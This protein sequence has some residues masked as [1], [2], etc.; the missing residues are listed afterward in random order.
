MSSTHM[1]SPPAATAPSIVLN[2][3][4]DM[5]NEEYHSA[6]GISKSHL[7]AIAGKSP[8][9]YW[10]KHI[11]PER[12][13]FNKT[14]A[15]VLGDAIHAAILEPHKFETE[16]AAAPACDRRTKE[17]KAVYEA[18][19]VRAVGKIILDANQFDIARRVRDACHRHPVASGF[20]AEGE[21]EQSYFATDM[22][23]GELIKC[24]TDRTVGPIN[25]GLIV[26]LKST[27]DASP[28]AFGRSAANYRYDVQVA[29]YYRVFESLHLGRP[30]SWVW[31][32][33]EKEPP[34]AIGCYFAQPEDIERAAHAAARDFDRIL[35]HRRSGQWPDYAVSIE[36]LYMPKWTVR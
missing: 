35:E 8:M 5:T 14:P 28:A 29:W 12:E 23:T 25:G 6:P 4:V 34:Y 26:D 32:A 11:N 22:F 15:L 7:D 17:G 2:G 31:I 3:L 18:F 10:Q 16:Y 19:L 21:T 36:P 33:F 27:E 1:L 20:L 13:P 24:R 9:H 30:E